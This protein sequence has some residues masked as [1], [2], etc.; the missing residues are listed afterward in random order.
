MT[1]YFLIKICVDG[2]KVLFI[3]IDNT[4]GYQTPKL[5]SMYVYPSGESPC[6]RPIQ[7]RLEIVVSN[8]L[9][10]KYI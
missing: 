7:T 10:F 6:S 9:P 1:S 2:I 4:A 3:I 8:I 5:P